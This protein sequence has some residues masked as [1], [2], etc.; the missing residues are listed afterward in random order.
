MRMFAVAQM[1]ATDSH[2]QVDR[3][4]KYLYAFFG[5]DTVHAL[6]PK[7]GDLLRSAIEAGAAVANYVELVSAEREYH[8]TQ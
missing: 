8:Q 5:R 1:S 2:Y 4:R 7:T 6:D 3:D